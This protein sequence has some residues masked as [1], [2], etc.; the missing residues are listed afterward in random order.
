MLLLC[1]VLN[2]VVKLF[3]AVDYCLER[4]PG[5]INLANPPSRCTGILRYNKLSNFPTKFIC[6]TNIMAPSIT[7]I[8]QVA[9]A[10]L[11]ALQREPLKPTGTLNSFESFDATPVIGREFTNVNLKEWLRTPNSDEILR[12]LAITSKSPCSSRCLTQAR[13][14]TQYR[15][16]GLPFSGCR[17]ILITTCRRS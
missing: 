12:E 11:K 10:T 14:T 6:C 9:P 7:D 15:S 16:A 8:P 2:R 3:F 17:M 13:I 4:T 5:G 1:G